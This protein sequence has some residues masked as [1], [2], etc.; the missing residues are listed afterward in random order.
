MFVI[1]TKETTSLRQFLPPDD[2]MQRAALATGTV[3]QSVSHT[4]E[5]C[6]GGGLGLL[7]FQC[8][9]EMDCLTLPLPH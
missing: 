9:I 4:G 1:L 2:V 6:Q 7:V 5:L 8:I 3:S